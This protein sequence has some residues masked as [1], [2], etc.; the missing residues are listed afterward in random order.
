M[1]VGFVGGISYRLGEG[2]D[3]V[4]V[5]FGG[6][7]EVSTMVEAG[8]GEREDGPARGRG[9]VEADARAGELHGGGSYRGVAVR[10]RAA[11]DQR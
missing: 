4:R 5:A 10:A 1:G 11:G 6:D 9:E 3:E 7:L 2:L 8:G